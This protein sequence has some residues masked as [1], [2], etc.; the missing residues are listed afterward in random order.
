L[1][2][3]NSKKKEPQSDALP[4]ELRHQSAATL[5][6]S[7]ECGAETPRV[8]RCLKSTFTPRSRDL[9]HKSPKYADIKVVRLHVLRITDLLAALMP[10]QT[11]GIGPESKEVGTKSPLE[12]EDP[13]DF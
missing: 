1:E 9:S 5:K 11:N 7:K 3:Q 12:S 2:V 10:E 4:A 8:E 6:Y 13:N